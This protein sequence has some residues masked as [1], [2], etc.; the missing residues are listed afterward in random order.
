MKR[1]MIFLSFYLLFAIE[2][3]AQWL[4][5]L[6][7]AAKEAAKNPV[8]CE[9]VNHVIIWVQ[10]LRVHIYHQQEKMLDVPTNI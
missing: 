4:N 5:K 6:G 10:Q 3:D 8:I 9:K 7:N 1:F 2:P